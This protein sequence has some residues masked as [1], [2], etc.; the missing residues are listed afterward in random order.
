MFGADATGI[1]SWALH[2]LFIAAK[3]A[4]G[5]AECVLSSAVGAEEPC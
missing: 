5:P 3:A 2:V 4:Q 1:F